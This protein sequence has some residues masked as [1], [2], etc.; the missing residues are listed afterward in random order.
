MSE[1][2]SVIGC[3]IGA[4]IFGTMGFAFGANTIWGFI[5]AIAATLMVIFTVG[6]TAKSFQPQLGKRGG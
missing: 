5:S 4:V 1:F 3:V 6:V 2:E